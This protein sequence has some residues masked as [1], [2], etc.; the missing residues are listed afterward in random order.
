VHQHG[1]TTPLDDSDRWYTST[2]ETEASNIKVHDSGIDTELPKSGT[3]EGGGRGT[4]SFSL[5]KES[6][7][8][9]FGDYRTGLKLVTNNLSM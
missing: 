3:R 6:V 5:R 4:S 7:K 9:V 2:K 8:R 1:S